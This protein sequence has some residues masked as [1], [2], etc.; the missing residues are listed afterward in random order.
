[1]LW[2]MLNHQNTHPTVY[3]ID[4]MVFCHFLSQEKGS[5]ENIMS[6]FLTKSLWPLE[7]LKIIQVLL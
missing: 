1:M 5:L 2:V 3:Q 4:E 7:K 6:D